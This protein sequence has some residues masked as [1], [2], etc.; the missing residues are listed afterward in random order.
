[1]L[2]GAD[3]FGHAAARGDTAFGAQGGDIC[4]L[5]RGGLRLARRQARSL[6]RVLSAGARRRPGSGSVGRHFT[7]ITAFRLLLLLLLARL[8]ASGR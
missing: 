3:R 2:R 4:R 5:D 8:D 7:F 1:M 6:A